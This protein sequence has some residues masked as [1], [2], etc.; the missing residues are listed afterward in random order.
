RRRGCT[1]YFFATRRMKICFLP[2]GRHGSFVELLI[3]I[4]TLTHSQFSF[5]KTDTQP[6]QSLHKVSNKPNRS[7][8]LI[9]QLLTAIFNNQPS[10][11]NPSKKGNKILLSYGFS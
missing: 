9:F 6:I 7:L 10:G 11:I 5:G 1:K 2:V 4:Q 3:T 8:G